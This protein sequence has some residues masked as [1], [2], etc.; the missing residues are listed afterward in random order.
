MLNGAYAFLFALF[1]PGVALAHGTEDHSKQ[2][3]TVEHVHGA[4]LGHPGDPKAPAR[5][6]NVTMTDQMRFNPAKIMVRPGETVRL[7][8]RNAG[9]LKHELV[10]G[11]MEELR[12]HA[13]LMLKF[14]EMEHEDPNA[15]SLEPGKTGTLVWKFTAKPGEYDFGCLVPGH[16][17]GG[18]V[19]KIVVR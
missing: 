9:T 19:G 6:I 14:P 15:V 11:T 12:E 18:M 3:M 8:V 7:V 16:F 10:L 17:E 1:I 2:A 13:A 5:T 4:V